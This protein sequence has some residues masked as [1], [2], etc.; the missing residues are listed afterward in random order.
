MTAFRDCAPRRPHDGWT[1]SPRG[2]SS[3][4]RAE[5]ARRNGVCASSAR[6]SIAA[7]A[8]GA[9]ALAAI[10]CMK[11]A[12]LRARSRSDRAPGCGIPIALQE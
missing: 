6:R 4:R 12:E 7:C 9:G 1:S 2:A 3:L 8:V 11:P 10:D 5:L